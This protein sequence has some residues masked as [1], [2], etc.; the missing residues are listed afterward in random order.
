MSLQDAIDRSIKITG[1]TCYFA[2]EAGNWCLSGET[3]DH[4]NWETDD[5]PAD[6]REHAEEDAVDY[7]VE[8]HDLQ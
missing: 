2:Y 8:F 1:G 4:L 6:S 7:L 3:V 5:Y